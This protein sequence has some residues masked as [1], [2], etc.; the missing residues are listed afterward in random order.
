[1]NEGQN[2]IMNYFDQFSGKILDTTYLDISL[3]KWLLLLS[4]TAVLWT[5]LKYAISR[6]VKNLEVKAK[7][8]ETKWDDVLYTFLRKTHGVFLFL[9]SLFVTSKILGAGGQA[10]SLFYKMLVIATFFQCAL[11]GN[12]LVAFG[13]R[14]YLRR[15]HGGDENT[16]I[17]LS[18]Y[19]AVS[20]TA[21]FVLWVVLFLLLL[22][23]LGVNITAL[24]TGLGIG[25]IAIALAV[26]N[27]LGD[28]FA[29]LSIVLDKP[30]EVGD[31]IVVDGNSG[32]VESIGLKTSRIKSLSGEQLVYPNR[33]LV[34]T[35]IQ[36]FKRMQ[37]RRIVFTFGVAYDTPLEKLKVI[38][39][40]VRDLIEKMENAKVD[41]VHFAKFND[42]SLD[43]EVVYIMQVP[44][45][46]AYMD[47]QQDLNF[48]LFARF[49]EE[50]IEFAYPTRT[51]LVKN[52]D[53]PSLSSTES[54]PLNGQSREIESPH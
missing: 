14:R 51:L 24:I 15:H 25:G 6:G 11:W 52:M 26:Q 50:G 3:T 44:D 39:V 21:K 34:E 10:S 4:I 37:T 33:K 38:P 45:Y 27:I 47:V 49:Q 2:F 42:S 53:D 16:E 46:L 36:N 28:I 48:S 54:K 5:L 8:T 35:H 41:R 23:N 9:L 20:I 7:L 31:F 30:F 40:I 18:A 1:M 29:S 43:Y 22:D 12:E 19:S 32:T 13:L 17:H